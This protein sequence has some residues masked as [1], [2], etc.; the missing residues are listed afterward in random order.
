MTNRERLIRELTEMSS[1]QLAE[2]IRE[3]SEDIIG[4]R[5]REM[6]CDD[7]HDAHNGRCIFS[8]NEAEGA[9]D[10]GESEYD[11]CPTS[12]AEWLDNECKREHILAY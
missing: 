2:E 10:D 7:C 1:E 4:E 6:V 11:G 12:M 9:E 5:L 3:F 8:D